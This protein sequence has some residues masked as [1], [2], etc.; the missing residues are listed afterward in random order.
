MVSST[1]DPEH[2][3][4]RDL[5]DLTGRVAAVTG[6]GSGM[7]RGI[8]VRLAEA[9]AHVLCLDINA[10][11]AAST[12]AIIAD[13]GGRAESAALDVG[14]QADFR[15]IVADYVDRQ[16]RLDVMCNIAGVTSLLATVIDMAADEFEQAFRVH[17]KGVL[18]G[19]QAVLPTMLAQ[20]SGSI[21]NMS[22]TTIDICRRLTGDYGVGKIAVAALTRVLAQEVGPSGV[23]VNAIAPGF[24]ATPGFLD[25][26]P[27]GP[28]RDAHFQ[29][30]FDMSPMARISSIEE[31]GN[32]V[33]YLASPASSFV[34][35]QILRANGGVSMPW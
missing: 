14:N 31:I 5:L 22:S 29:S 9:G 33:L 15:A 17:F 34:T 32:Q 10:G 27:V 7:G 16:G 11:A 20:G 26:H 8:S 6:A 21:V 18:F 28:K 12:A 35:G 4:V 30:W 2:I 23:R 1:L 25:R 3:E 19:C 13:A 24:V